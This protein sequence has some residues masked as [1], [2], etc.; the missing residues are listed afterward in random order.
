MQSL[1]VDLA[2]DNSTDPVDLAPIFA[3][4]CPFP[5]SRIAL[6]DPAVNAFLPI[7]RLGVHG[8]LFAKRLLEPQVILVRYKAE[9][10]ESGESESEFEVGSADR[11]D[12]RSRERTVAEAIELV[13]RWRSLHLNCSKPNNARKKVNLQEAA[14]MLGVSK[15]SLDDYYCQLRLAEQYGFDFQAHF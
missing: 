10:E 12:M 14:R 2:I 9:K 4:Y 13:K 6:Y 1:I 7:K 3:Q 11:K 8:G 5:R 15:K